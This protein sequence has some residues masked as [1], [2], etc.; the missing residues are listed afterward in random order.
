MFP[1]QQTI[2]EQQ[3]VNLGNTVNSPSSTGSDENTETN[4]VHHNKLNS[5]ANNIVNNNNN[6]YNNN[7]NNKN[8]ASKI[9]K[10]TGH[11]KKTSDAAPED[12]FDITPSNIRINNSNNATTRSYGKRNA[13]DEDNEDNDNEE[14][15]EDYEDDEKEVKFANSTLS[16]NK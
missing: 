14:E 11:N 3:I 15:E 8:I 13:A 2:L 16:H 4:T 1:A 6:Y 9:G 5:I 10:K 7:N 12:L